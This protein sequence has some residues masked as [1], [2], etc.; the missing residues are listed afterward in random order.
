MKRLLAL[1][2]LAAAGCGDHSQTTPAT[3]GAL[4]PAGAATH[5]VAIVSLPPRIDVVGTVASEK[6][7][8]LSAR[9]S[10][11]VQDVFA[12]A[13]DRVKAG[14]TVVAL[15]DRDIREQLAAAEAQFKQ[16]GREYQRIRGLFDKNAT[17][18]QALT[19]AETGYTAAKAQLDGVKVMLSYAQVTS[20]IDGIV[21]E[22]RVEAGDLANPGQP[23]LTVYDPTR[24]RLEAAVPV[25]LVPRVQLGQK[26]EVLLDQSAGALKGEVTEIVSEVDPLSRTRKVKIRLT[27]ADGALPGTFGR[28]WVDDEPRPTI[29]VP[30]SAV[31]RVGQLEMVK[32]VRDGIALQRLV[33]TGPKTGDQV[34][35]L[36]GLASGD[37]ILV[38]PGSEG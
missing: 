12:S 30:A 16:A 5:T 10:A 29:L 24:M 8:T 21:T 17:T 14:Q 37:V 1:A 13:G 28:L 34:E 31:T 32:V 6:S 38:T 2:L 36:S 19:A 11:Y 23:L 9:L 4:V 27:D 3:K 18:E 7:V 22:R 26:V 15:D 33:R 35:I 20:P 25:R